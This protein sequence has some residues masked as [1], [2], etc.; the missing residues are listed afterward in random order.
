MVAAG[1]LAWR[2][3][4][5]SEERQQFAESVGKIVDA[6][7]DPERRSEVIKLIGSELGKGI[8][9]AFKHF[10]QNPGYY[11]GYLMGT[12]AAGGVV[13]KLTKVAALLPSWINWL[14]MLSIP[15]SGWKSRQRGWAATAGT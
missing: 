3:T 1:K 15:S 6:L 8:V 4:T 10:G 7:K 2:L 14:H 11:S 12:L 13:G 5:D 9:D